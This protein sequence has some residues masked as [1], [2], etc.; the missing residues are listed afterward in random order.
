M[1]LTR[2]QGL[3]HMCGFGGVF[4]LEHQPAVGCLSSRL[5]EGWQCA[6]P[7]FNGKPLAGNKES[8]EEQLTVRWRRAGRHNHA[9]HKPRQWEPA[10]SG[11]S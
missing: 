6:L 5:L 1:I 10:A 9:L 7:S 8:R 4:V 3:G 11:Q 2:W